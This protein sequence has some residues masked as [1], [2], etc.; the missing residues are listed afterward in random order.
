MGGMVY[1]EVLI[2]NIIIMSFSELLKPESKGETRYEEMHPEK[3]WKKQ[4]A[5]DAEKVGGVT[6]QDITDDDNTEDDKKWPEQ[7]KSRK[8][9]YDFAQIKQKINVNSRAERQAREDDHPTPEEILAQLQ[10]SAEWESRKAEWG[11]RNQIA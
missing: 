3:A 4:L 11:D 9:A 5:V 6:P 2:P 10:N 7:W 8:P 1:W